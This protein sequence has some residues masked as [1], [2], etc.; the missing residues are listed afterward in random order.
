M[1]DIARPDS[2]IKKKKMKRAAYGVAGLTAILLVT[3][4]VSQLKPAAPSVDKATLWPD[5]VKRGPDGPPGPRHRH[6]GARGHALDSGD[7]PPAAS[8][9][10][11][12]APA[13]T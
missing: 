13:P 8:S 1:V 4:F 10:S 7:P 5:V 11:C 2:V 12:C 3:V 6:A 9:G